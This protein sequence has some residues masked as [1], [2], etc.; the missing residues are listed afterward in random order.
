MMLTATS[1]HSPQ[2]WFGVITTL[3]VTKNAPGGWEFEIVVTSWKIW[4]SYHFQLVA[5]HSLLHPRPRCCNYDLLIQ[6]ILGKPICSEGLTGRGYSCN[7]VR[8]SYLPDC[9]Y[10]FPVFDQ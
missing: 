7:Y 2:V 4:S 8:N 9:K 5:P 3:V 10:L 6:S 1:G